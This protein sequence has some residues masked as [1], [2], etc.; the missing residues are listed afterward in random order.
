MRSLLALLLVPLLFLTAC[1]GGDG[2]S[3]ADGA[4]AAGSGDLSGVTVSGPPD[5]KPKVQ[6][7][8]GFSVDETTVKVLSEGEG[9]KVGESDLVTV[10]YVGINAKNGEEFDSSWSRNE[11]ATFNLGPSMITGFN[12]ALAGQQV[13]SRVLVAIPP[14]DG[15]GEQGNPQARIGGEDTLVFAIDIRETTSSQA[16]GTKVEPPATV[17]TL[18][19]DDQGVP[20]GF[21]SDKDTAPAPDQP[22]SH[23]LIEGKGEKIKKGQT[24]TLQ[25][26]AQVYG[27]DKPFTGTWGG[28]PASIPI[29]TGQPIKCFDQLV[30]A[31]L[32][33]RVMLICP[34]DSAFGKKG[35]PQAGIKP[36]DSVIFAVDVLA[37][38]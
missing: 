4:A 38:S 21:S 18:Q 8:D 7:E 5:E 37:A 28:A 10:D 32:G 12:K 17:P 29:G 27:S 31:K 13:G 11:P 30:G 35:N 26:L 24:V 22:T 34:P 23:V 36:D 33:S 3:G 1:G 2:D 25:F 16:T 9:P 15:Y 20:T 6:V 19:V 14:K